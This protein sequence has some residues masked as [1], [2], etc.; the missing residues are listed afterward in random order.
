MMKLPPD[1]LI[2]ELRIIAGQGERATFPHLSKEDFAQMDAADFMQSALLF[3]RDLKAAGGE[4]GL[5]AER[6][7]ARL[8]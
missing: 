5:R 1:D 4:V 2:E 6:I 8:E 7:L 3:L